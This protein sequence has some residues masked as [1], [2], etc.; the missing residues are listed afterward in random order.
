MPTYRFTR[1]FHTFNNILN[2]IYHHY[3]IILFH[4]FI[5]NYA[6]TL[7]ALIELFIVIEIILNQS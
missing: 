1:S 6:L 2:I 5:L 3:F 7:G 4:N